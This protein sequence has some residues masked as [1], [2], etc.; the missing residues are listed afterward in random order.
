MLSLLPFHVALKHR[1]S[2]SNWH[3]LHAPRMLP[4]FSGAAV[5][6]VKPIGAGSPL[7]LPCAVCRTPVVAMGYALE[8]GHCIPEL[9]H[10][11]F[12][13]LL[14][15]F[16][17]LIFF[18]SLSLVELCF[19][20]VCAIF[21]LTLVDFIHSQPPSARSLPWILYCPR[22]FSSSSFFF[23]MATKTFAWWL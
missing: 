20:D 14:H 2:G 18:S 17:F 7:G 9:Q 22:G 8:Q 1:R 12:P 19:P 11:A 16:F 13:A 4:D 6:S 5:V 23:S 10:R 21:P 15:L 3:L